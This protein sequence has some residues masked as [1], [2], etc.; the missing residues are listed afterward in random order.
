MSAKVK[1]DGKFA[2][3]KTPLITIRRPIQAYG[4]GRAAIERFEANDHAWYKAAMQAAL[5]SKGIKASTRR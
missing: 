4:Y 1:N 2:K 3:G 5:A